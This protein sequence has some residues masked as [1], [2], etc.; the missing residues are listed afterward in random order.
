MLSLTTTARPVQF[1]LTPV[2]S[3][4]FPHYPR[5]LS[6]SQDRL[7]LVRP[8]HC[9]LVHLCLPRIHSPSSPTPNHSEMMHIRPLLLPSLSPWALAR[10]LKNSVSLLL[11]LALSVPL[12]QLCLYVL[13]YPTMSQ[14]PFHPLPTIPIANSVSILTLVLLLC[15]TQRDPKYQYEGAPL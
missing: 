12:L 9:R 15:Q 1:M 10:M 8:L 11:T 2:M 5:S 14:R 4:L 6:P 7:L 3:L 13:S